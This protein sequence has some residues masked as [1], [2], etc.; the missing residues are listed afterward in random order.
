MSSEGGDKLRIP[1]E[2]KTDD[3]KEIQDLINDLDK[4]ESDIDV[5]KPRKGRGT[6]DATSRSAFARE[7]PFEERGGIFGGGQENAG[8]P[9]KT[10][11]TKSRAAFQRENEFSKMRD[12]VD[13]LQGTQGNMI[14]QLVNLG[15]VGGFAKGTGGAAVASKAAQS[16]APLSNMAKG[17]MKGGM[18]GAMGMTGIK[19][20][21]GKAGIY[22]MVV[23]IVMEVFQSVIDFAYRPGGPLDKRFKRD[24]SKEDVRMIDLREKSDISQ[25]RRI[26]RVTTSSSLRG[27]DSQARS[28]LDI[29]KSGQRVFDMDGTFM[30]KN[31]GV[32][33][34]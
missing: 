15:F 19:G 5:L 18:M 4:A 30:I 8:V 13:E 3:L 7:E 24:M 16:V 25:G 22:G 31:T 28:S 26:V 12:Q 6:G 27:T 11:D 33:E 1:I 20:L 23:M 29:Y 2:I 32:A 9:L 21:I 14:G 17:G 10:R 34:V